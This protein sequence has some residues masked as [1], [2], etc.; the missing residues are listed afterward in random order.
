MKWLIIGIFLLLIF[1]IFLKIRLEI[2][3][4]HKEETNHLLIRVSVLWQMIR[5]QKKIEFKVKADQLEVGVKSEKPEKDASKK[6]NFTISELFEQ[7]K[8]TKQLLAWTRSLLRIVFNFLHQV[9]I[10]KLQIYSGVGDLDAVKTAL[11]YGS[12]WGMAGN[13]I[14]LLHRIFR[15]DCT[16]EV[17]IA[18]FFYQNRFTFDCRCI[19]DFRLG[20]LMWAGLKFIFSWK[21]EKKFFIIPVIKSRSKTA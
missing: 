16:P 3:Y 11:M 5:F 7:M 12:F 4:L 13:L 17:E 18:P 8:R 14:A 9:H 10:R 2:E 20:H 1:F 21:G 15:F 19:I 6:S